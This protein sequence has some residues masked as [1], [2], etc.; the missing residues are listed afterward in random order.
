MMGNQQVVEAGSTATNREVHAGGARVL[1]HH[2]S[3]QPGF[4]RKSDG[5]DSPNDAGIVYE[6]GGSL[7][8]ECSQV[9]K[10][11]VHSAGVGA[12]VHGEAGFQNAARPSSLQC[13]DMIYG[14]NGKT[15]KRTPGRQVIG[16]T[17]RQ[18]FNPS[19]IV[20]RNRYPTSAANINYSR[21]VPKA[22]STC[23][24]L[25]C[26]WVALLEQQN[27]LCS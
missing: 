17:V 22:F 2:T 16:S 21:S 20:N 6:D 24:N 23:V 13:C 25:L 10:P 26:W 18:G 19:N 12:R 9:I 7:F 14:N 15:S 1:L 11:S 5:D 3:S 27:I 4:Q 8:P